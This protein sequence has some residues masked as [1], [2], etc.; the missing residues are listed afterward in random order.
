MTYD[1]CVLGAGWA[2]FSA[3]VDAARR[4]RSVCLID[5][6]E[7]GGTCLNRGCIPT[8]VF[9]AQSRKGLSFSEVQEKCRATVTRLR[10]GMEFLL[11]QNRITFLRGR[12]RIE[13]PKTVSVEGREAVNAKAFL[14]ATGSRP[15]E[16]ASLPIDHKKVVSSDDVFELPDLPER[17]LVVGGGVIGCEFSCFLRRMGCSVTLVELLPQLLTGFDAEVVRKLQQSLE[18]AGI[19]VV[20]GKDAASCDIGAYDKVLVATGRQAVAEDLWAGKV[21]IETAKGCVAV[22]RQLRTATPNIYAA[23]DCIGG[24]LLAHVAAYEGE[25]AVANIFGETANRDYAVVPT[26]VFTDPEIGAVGVTEEEAKKFGAEYSARTVH[27]LAVG[28]AHVLEETQGFVKVIADV[29]SGRLLGAHVIGVHA[30][31]LVNIFSLALKNKLGV[32]DLRHAVFAHPSIS[33]VVGEVAR[34]F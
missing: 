29:K 24:Y 4:K 26:S 18:K 13:D 7:L 21:K 2:G 34:S 23:G 11:K 12:G 5:K 28:M 17:W 31:E 19:E 3:A 22:D 25:L 6:A 10:S 15:K 30:S 32:K 1:L 9:I 8:K 16:L 33:E 14:I 20:L 27:F